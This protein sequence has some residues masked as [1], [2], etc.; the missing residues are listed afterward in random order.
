MT[1]LPGPISSVND[2]FLTDQRS[3]SSAIGEKSRMHSEVELD[4]SGTPTIIRQSHRC[5]PTIEVDCEDGDEECSLSGSVKGKKFHNLLIY[6][7]PLES[8]TK[9][10]M[11]MEILPLTHAFAALPA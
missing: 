10:E 4:V 11:D 2:C 8:Q 5:D 7:F 9:A 1:M 6:F 3:F